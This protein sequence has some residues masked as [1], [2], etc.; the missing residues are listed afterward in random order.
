[1]R[2]VGFALD[3]RAL[4]LESALCAVDPHPGREEEFLQVL[5]EFPGITHAYERE[6]TPRYWFTV[7][8]LPQRRREVLETL[9]AAAGAPLLVL[10]P[11]RSF[12]LEVSL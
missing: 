6:G 1:L 4:G 8:F 12:K 2:R 10:P 5:R 11:L 3:A 9:G 7:A